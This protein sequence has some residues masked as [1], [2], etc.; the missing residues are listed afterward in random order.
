[1]TVLAFGGIMVA[2]VRTI[3]Q[4][5]LGEADGRGGDLSGVYYPDCVLFGGVLGDGK[6]RPLENMRFSRRGPY[7]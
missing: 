7:R 3:A 1:M 4:S 6:D 2:L 5:M